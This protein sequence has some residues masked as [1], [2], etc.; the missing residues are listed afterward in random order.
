MTVVRA[1][2]RRVVG[3]CC[4]AGRSMCCCRGSVHGIMDE[5]GAV[6]RLQ[7]ACDSA[8]LALEAFII[9]GHHDAVGILERIGIQSLEIRLVGRPWDVLA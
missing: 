6:V 7:G 2:V 3:G 5:G 8:T 1:L 4:Q 9:V